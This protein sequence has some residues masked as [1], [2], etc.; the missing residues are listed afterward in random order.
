MHHRKIF[1]II[2]TLSG[3][4]AE[5]VMVHLL[6]HIDMNK[7]NPYLV[8]FEK[9]GQ[10]LKE[11]P[12]NIQIFYLK[13][14]GY[15]YGFQWLSVFQLRKLL[16]KERP[17]VIVSFI[18]YS[19]FIAFLARYLSMIKCCLVMSERVSLSYSEGWLSNVIR[20]IVMRSVYPKAHSII[21]NSEAMKR[22]L[23]EHF[24]IASEKIAVISNPV[25]I[26]KI[27]QLGREDVEHPWYKEDVPIIIAIGR[28]TMQKGF[29]Y[30][31]K[32]LNILVSEGVECR[33]IILG[34]GTEEKKLNKIA[35][36]LRVQNHVAF[37]GFQENP[38][39]YLAHS[40]MFVLS[41]NYEGFPNVLIEAMA[42]GIPSIATRCPTGPEEIITDGLDG[43]LVPTADEKALA[44]AMK[45]V[46]IDKDLRKRFS[47]AGKKRVECFRV[48]KVVKQ[49][50]DVITDTYTK[51]L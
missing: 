14:G 10:Y 34:K 6:R 21:V 37:L 40:T 8:L 23:L 5:K 33:L 2:P 15:K 19:N 38:Y 51:S 42:L 20:K 25:N 28:L 13:K 24:H 18:W 3:G 49:Y 16:K 44:H 27:N 36:H 41:S 47:N 17:D 46:L 11:L 1:F 9:K 48:D 7:F 35:G 50:E 45:R 22:E 43:I 31:I 30:L 4:G 39:K 26:E 29:H 12:S 32:A